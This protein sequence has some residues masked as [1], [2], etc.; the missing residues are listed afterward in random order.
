ME[1]LQVTCRED[2]GWTVVTAGGQ[3]DVATAPRFRESL[4]EAQYGGATDVLVDIGDIEFVDSFGLGVLIG[5]HKRA[6]T[7]D[8]QFVVVCD[9]QR[10]LQVLALTGLDAVLV[11]VPDQ[12]AVLGGAPR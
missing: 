12:A 8:A 1:L 2:Q 10:T 3:L 9:R 4:I 7:H 6:R 11:V 5:A